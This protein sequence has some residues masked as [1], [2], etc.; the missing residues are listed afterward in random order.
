[1]MATG[2]SY[3]VDFRRRREG[4]TDYRSRKSLVLSRFPR[5]VVRGTLKHM[6]TQIIKAKSNG[7]EIIVFAH[8]REL[9]KN[10]GWKG[11][12]GNVSAA[13]LT[14]LL[15]GYKALSQNVKRVV[16]DLGL[17]SPSKGSRILA[18]LKG[19]LDAGLE[20]PH[21]SD[22]LPDNERVQGQHISD[23]AQKLSS[24][25]TDYQRRFS[26]YLEKGLHPEQLPEHFSEVKEKI[27][28]SFRRKET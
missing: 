9:T 1:M 17:R 19:A 22:I 14:G 20:I 24:N 4:K 26:Q 27:V 15:C 11:D 3:R 23:Y 21:S 18:T 12:C 10:Y 2:P 6:I 13:Y 28:S 25:P 5:L 7:D 8:S 16:L